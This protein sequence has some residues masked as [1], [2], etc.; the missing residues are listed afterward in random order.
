MENVTNMHWNGKSNTKIRMLCY[1]QRTIKYKALKCYIVIFLGKKRKLTFNIDKFW[2]HSMPSKVQITPKHPDDWSAVCTVTLIV[3]LWS[4]YHRVLQACTSAFATKDRLRSHMIRHEG[5]VTCNICGKMLSA[6]YITSHLKTHSQT[7]FTS[8]C[9]K[10]TPALAPHSSSTSSSTTS[11]W[12]PL[13]SAAPNQD[14]THSG[15]HLLCCGDVTFS[16]P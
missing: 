10:G 7:G 1:L 16:S 8:P 3:C 14:G 6:A 2:C 4:V 12:P 11:S 15:G 5:K 9:N 13:A